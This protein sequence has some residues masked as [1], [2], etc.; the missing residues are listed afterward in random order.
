MLRIF[1][2]PNRHLFWIFSWTLFALGV[3]L[4]LR[5]AHT[6]HLENAED[7]IVPTIQQLSAGFIHAALTPAEEDDTSDL[8]DHPS[9]IQQLTHS[10]LWKDTAASGKRFL[11]SLALMLPA[12]FLGLQMGAF[13]WIK[14]FFGRFVLFFDK[15]VALSILPILFIAFGIGEFAKVMLIVIGVAPTIIMDS[16]NLTKS[17]PPEQVIRGF[18]LGAGDLGVT[19]RVLLPQIWPRVLNSIRL[20]LK[21]IMLFLFAGEMI[22]SQDGLAYRI[23]LMQRHMGMDVIIPYVLWTALLLFSIDFALRLLIRLTNPWFQEV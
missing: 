17:V 23:A 19:Y 7:R 14:C 6:R 22:A 3:L 20:N 5:T 15:I 13:P 16:L 12:V 1:A 18:T 4:Y 2:V 10:M 9:L 8:G 11:I 21:A